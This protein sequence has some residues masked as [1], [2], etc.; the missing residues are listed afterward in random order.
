[1]DTARTN[2]TFPQ[3]TSRTDNT[4]DTYRSEETSA[5]STV[6]I[7]PF[8][9]EKQVN[10]EVNLEQLDND[11]ETE[12]RSWGGKPINKKHTLKKTSS[13]S[14]K[15]S[16]S[17]VVSSKNV[18]KNSP[19]SSLQ[20]NIASKARTNVISEN[21]KKKDYLLLN[22][23]VKKTTYEKSQKSQGE[24]KKVMDRKRELAAACIQLWW[25]KI[26]IRKTAG[27]AAMQRMMEN[28]RKEMEF[29]LTLE[30]KKVS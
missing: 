30:R 1:M 16:S 22:G 27:A 6:N 18:N 29:K 17:S 10:N 15:T 12:I 7:N 5:T 25:R 28:K 2:D 20:K 21:L 24:N 3:D 23:N 19:R 9:Y 4:W 26:R 13:I 14:S 11:D 8:P